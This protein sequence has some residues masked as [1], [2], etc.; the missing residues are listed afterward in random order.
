MYGRDGH[1]GHV[2]INVCE[3]FHSLKLRITYMK[4]DINLLGSL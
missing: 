3:K 1:L 2:T 4:F